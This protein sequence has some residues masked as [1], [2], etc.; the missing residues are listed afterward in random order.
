MD[1]GGA[2][3]SPAERD[4]GSASHSTARARMPRLRSPYGTWP[5]YLS[6]MVTDLTVRV[7][8]R[9]GWVSGTTSVERSS[10]SRS[11]A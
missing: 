2:Y 6:L 3:T 1:I 9:T 8:R 10:R 4:Y 5:G 11:P 7:N